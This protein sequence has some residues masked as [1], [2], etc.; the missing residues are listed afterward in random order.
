MI[1]F[2][3]DFMT[4]SFSYMLNLKLWYLPAEMN[5]KHRKGVQ[6]SK[7]VFPIIKHINMINFRLL[8]MAFYLT[9]RGLDYVFIQK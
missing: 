7:I 5:L 9:T 6:W 1:F 4:Y 3:Y 2:L 8:N